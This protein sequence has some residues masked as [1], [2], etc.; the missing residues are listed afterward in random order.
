[1][2]ILIKKVN[3]SSLESIKEALKVGYTVYHKSV[4]SEVVKQKSG[5]Y[6]V[7]TPN[8]NKES[9]LQE[10]LSAVILKNGFADF[11]IITEERK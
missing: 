8:K 11:F 9:Y 5:T 1:M 6:N 10:Q 7:T 4:H 2:T 3:L